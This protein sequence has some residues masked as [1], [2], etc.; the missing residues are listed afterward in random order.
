MKRHV[1]SGQATIELAAI[2]VGLAA[3]ILGMIFVAGICMGNNRTFLNSKL[4][5]ETLSRSGSDSQPSE[6][7]EFSYWVYTTF[8][9]A[10]NTSA[11]QTSNYSGKQEYR[12]NKD[13]EMYRYYD[14]NKVNGGSEKLTIPFLADD[15]D[16][17][18]NN[19]S[20][21]KV[22]PYMADNSTSDTTQYSYRWYN[23]D[24]F[25]SHLG[26]GYASI[27]N[28]FVAAN[29]VTAE[30]DNTGAKL[31][32]M[33]AG[34]QDNASSKMYNAFY[35]WFGVQISPDQLRKI[36]SNTTYMPNL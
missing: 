19:N 11:S 27:T 2:L 22:T 31:D 8:S 28:S 6:Q 26:Q 29:L 13:Y 20:I 17:R 15:S 35:K 14:E 18:S 16:T 1:Q 7:K 34:Y 24:S 9:N 25:D 4:A 23:P 21:G 5:T 10:V 3:I 30:S 36:P 12:L 33:T 32:R